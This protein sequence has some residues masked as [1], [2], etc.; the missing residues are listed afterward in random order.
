MRQCA[1]CGRECEDSAL[2][3][4]LDHTSLVP[5]ASNSAASES[6]FRINPAGK[7]SLSAG[8]VGNGAAVVLC[9]PLLI[10]HPGAVVGAASWASPGIIVAI[11]TVI[12]GLTGALFSFRSCSRW[13]SVTGLLLSVSPWPLSLLLVNLIATIHGLHLGP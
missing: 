9:L 10:L 7:L 13:V 5:S 3:C 8:L 4:P 11:C 2:E 12:P 6:T 1:Y